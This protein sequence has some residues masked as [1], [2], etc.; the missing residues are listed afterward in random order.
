MKQVIYVDVLI[1]V[2]LFINYFI[3]LSVVKILNLTL[4]RFRLILASSLGAIYSL[5]IFLPQLNF[6]LSLLIKLLMSIS[7]ILLA[8]GLLKIHS[9]L[10]ITAYFYT[11]NFI[12]AGIIFF[13]WYFISSNGIFIKNGMIYFNISPLFLI[14]STLITYFLMKLFNILIGQK[15][16]PLNFCTI[17]IIYKGQQVTLK[18]KIDTGNTLREPFSNTPV[19]VTNYDVV[20]DILKNE[21]YQKFFKTF[22]LSDSKTAL[23][24]RMVPFKTIMGEGLLP[25]FKA[26]KIIINYKKHIFEKNAFIAICKENILENSFSALINPEL[27]N[28]Y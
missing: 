23:K 8:F 24:I 28:L 11:I 22:N 17:S 25:A 10:K 14:A 3:L 26:D 2:N 5:I 19:V 27:L 9:L 18:A 15:E 20:K 7:I 12:F 21:S 13:V 6:F 16:V 4:K 1:C